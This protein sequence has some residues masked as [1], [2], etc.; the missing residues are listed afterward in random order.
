MQ[1]CWKTSCTFL[2]LVFTVAERFVGKIKCFCRLTSPEELI[3]FWPRIDIHVYS[4]TSLSKL[5]ILYLD[6][7]QERTFIG[8]LNL[9][10]LMRKQLFVPFTRGKIQSED[11]WTHEQTIRVSWTQMFLP[12]IAIWPREKRLNNMVLYSVAP[13]QVDCVQP[14]TSLK[15]YYLSLRYFLVYYAGWRSQPSS[16]FGQISFSS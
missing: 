3:G 10:V 8:R 2:L 15:Q 12:K 9:D 4:I 16:K 11:S 5:C 6:F 7:E 1:Q 13:K 14:P